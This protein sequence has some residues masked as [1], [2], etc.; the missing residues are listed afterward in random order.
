MDLG[1]VVFG[2]LGQ[3]LMKAEIEC[4]C[5][6]SYLRLTQ[7]RGGKCHL[8]AFSS[9]GKSQPNPSLVPKRP[10]ALATIHHET[11][12]GEPISEYIYHTDA[13]IQEGSSL[14]PSYRND[15]GTTHASHSSH[16]H[17]SFRSAYEGDEVNSVVEPTYEVSISYHDNYS[18]Y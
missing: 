16:S 6:I 13:W 3:N 11:G 9:T 10:L 18:T 5:D 7:C 12:R 15:G 2:G 17:N 1:L 8:L 4:K 14:R